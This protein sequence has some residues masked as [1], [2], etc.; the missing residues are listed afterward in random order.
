MNP[1]KKKGEKKKSLW[2]GLFS[3]L[4]KFD[5]KKEVT[6]NFIYHPPK[7]A[8]KVAKTISYSSL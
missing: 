1:D 3:F 5:L 6:R 8:S 7:E 4:D 2:S